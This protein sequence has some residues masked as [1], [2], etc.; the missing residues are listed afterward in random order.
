MEKILFTIGY[1]V[2]TGN[3]KLMETDFKEFGW[4]K[5]EYTTELLNA[6]AIAIGTRVGSTVKSPMARKSLLENLYVVMKEVCSS[7]DKNENM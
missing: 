7:I 5:T 3:R 4:T 1:D 6:L 2:E